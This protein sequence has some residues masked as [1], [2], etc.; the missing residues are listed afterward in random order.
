LLAAFSN[1]ELRPL[2]FTTF[3][4]ARVIDAFRFMA[5]AK[6]IGKIVITKPPSDTVARP[7][8]TQLRLRDNATY[9][10]TGGL[11]GLGLET[12]RWMVREGARN[13]ALMGRR[14]PDP[15]TEAVLHEMTRD[16]ARIAIE[17]C[18]VSDEAELHEALNRISRSMPPLRGI[19]HAAG[20]LDDGMLEEQTW[21]RFAGVMAPKVRGAWNLHRLTLSLELDFF[22]LFSSVAV[23]VGSPGQGNYAA[24]NAFMDGLAHHRKAKGLSA[25]SIDWGIWAETGMAARLATKNAERWSS[26]GLRPIQLDEGMAKLGEMLVSPQAQIVAAPIDWSRMFT[27]TVSNRSPSLFSEVIK[28]SGGTISTGVKAPGEDNFVRHLSGQPAGR[29][30]AI[31][32]AHVESAASR[33]LGATG[34]TSFDPQR[35]L[36]ELGLDSLMS[37]ELRNALAT[38]LGRSLPTTLLFDYPTVESLTHYLAK[39]VLNLELTD[40]TASEIRVPPANKDLEE[41]REMSESEAE[42]LLLAEL[43]Q[44]KK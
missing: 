2:P 13:L 30:L 17:K 36:H 31:L 20:V 1:G 10:V 4:T 22:A 15:K 6:H 3:P 18:D 7:S 21:S 23:L 8:P 35:P 9:L 42:S 44:L 40:P 43:D 37:V 11:G 26:L 5:Q 12:A 41:L 39:N 28:A 38:S 14:P 19:V 25:L 29:R 32:K 16:G 27:G 33:A 24:A 34:S